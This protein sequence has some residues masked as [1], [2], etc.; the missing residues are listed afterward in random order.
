MQAKRITAIG[1]LLPKTASQVTLAFMPSFFTTKV[2]IEKVNT[3][4]LL[5]E[6]KF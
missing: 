4:F 2:L 1:L 6:S 3:P 5:M